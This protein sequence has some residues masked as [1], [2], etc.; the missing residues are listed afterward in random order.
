MNRRNLEHATDGSGVF[1]GKTGQ[2]EWKQAAVNSAGYL[3]LAELHGDDAPMSMSYV[4][5]EIEV[6][7]DRKT[8]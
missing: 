8:L 3:D 5:A 4:Y 1:A 6:A 2:I 7:N